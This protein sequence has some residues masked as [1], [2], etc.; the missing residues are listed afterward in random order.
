MSSLQILRCILKKQQSRNAQPYA[1]AAEKICVNTAGCWGIGIW[2]WVHL[3]FWHCCWWYQWGNDYGASAQFKPHPISKPPIDHQVPSLFYSWPIFCTRGP[4]WCRPS[5][6]L[7]ADGW[8]WFVLK[9]EYCWLVAAGC[10]W[11]IRSERKVLLAGG[12]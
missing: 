1:A 9:E 3:F 4:S 12:W 2:L 8:C 7:V 11:L 5:G 10:W 6:W